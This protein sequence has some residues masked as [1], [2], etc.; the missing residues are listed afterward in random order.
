ML[1]LLCSQ[2]EEG[3]PSSFHSS[4]VTWPF[5]SLC[6]LSAYP[7]PAG[8]YFPLVA[9]QGGKGNLLS[10]ALLVKIAVGGNC[11]QSMPPNLC[12]LISLR[13]GVMDVRSSVSVNAYL[14]IVCASWPT[15]ISLNV[16][17]HALVTSYFLTSFIH[18]ERLLDVIGGWGN[19]GETFPYSFSFGYKA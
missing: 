4:I 6:F 17:L 8:T 9:A 10:E 15:N 2:S 14:D 16:T 5:Q 13:L 1:L 11:M 18:Q 3:S 12:W 7:F 19:P